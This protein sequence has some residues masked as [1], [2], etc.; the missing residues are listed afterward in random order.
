M[1]CIQL[2]HYSKRGQ[3]CQVFFCFS[4]IIF[5]GG[6]EGGGVGSI[7]CFRDGLR[8]SG[9]RGRRACFIRYAPLK[10]VDFPWIFWIPVR[11]AGRKATSSPFS[12]NPIFAVCHVPG[13]FRD[14]RAGYRTRWQSGMPFP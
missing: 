7:L 11:T 1:C 12:K 4:G 6:R 14:R 2:L 10:G 3:V 13:L 9:G 5:C 8:S